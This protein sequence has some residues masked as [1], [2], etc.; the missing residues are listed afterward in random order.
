MYATLDGHLWQ[1]LIL[2]QGW[3]DERH[4]AWLATHWRQQF[5]NATPADA[6]SLRQ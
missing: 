5:L 3:T 6:V 2:E 1:R 4:A